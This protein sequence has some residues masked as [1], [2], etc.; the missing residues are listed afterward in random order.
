[1]IA[2]HHWQYL[3]TRCG[4]IVFQEERDPSRTHERPE[5]LGELRRVAFDPELYTAGLAVKMGGESKR[6]ACGNWFVSRGELRCFVC[7]G[8]SP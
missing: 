4:T 1:M 8:R 6:C 3:C 5:C 7:G 2:I